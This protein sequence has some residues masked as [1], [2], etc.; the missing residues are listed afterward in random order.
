[1][2]FTRDFTE[3]VGLLLAGAGVGVWG[4]SFA[5]SD[6]AI[7]FGDLP[8][9][10]AAAVGLT[11]YPVRDR[12][13]IGSYVLGIQVYCRGATFSIV[14]DLREAVRAQLQNRVN[15]TVGG[16]FCSICNWQSGANLGL[17]GNSNVLAS[18]SYYFITGR[19]VLA[20]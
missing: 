13:D 15:F 16:N 19:P 7:V 6:T 12:G 11:P 1:V 10:P 20:H 4:S 9:K 18:D 5:D 8:Q 17:D 2:S 14:E 3:G